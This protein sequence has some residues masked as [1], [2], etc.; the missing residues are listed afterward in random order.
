MSALNVHW[1]FRRA[2]TLIELLVVVAITG[3]LAALLMPALSSAKASGRQIRCMTN[4]KQIGLGVALYGQ[5]N[6]DWIV[7]YKGEIGDPASYWNYLL[8]KHLSYSREVFHCPSARTTWPPPNWYWQA[9]LYINYGYNLYGLSKTI[10]TGTAWKKFMQVNDPATRILVADRNEAS[11]GTGYTPQVIKAPS[12]YQIGAPHHGGAVIVFL[13][14]H[15]SWTP[16]GEIKDE[17]WGW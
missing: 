4:L 8:E 17:W 12:V 14:G 2:F 3:I 13:D 1:S 6:D 16:F 10:T 5:E 7:P 9:H 15:C 11:H